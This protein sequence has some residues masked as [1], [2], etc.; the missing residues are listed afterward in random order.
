MIRHHDE[1]LE[2]LV[3]PEQESYLRQSL[4]LI[5]E[6]SQLALLKEEQSL[7][8]ASIDKAL[9]LIDGYYDTSRE[10]AQRVI[11]RLEEL[12]EVTVEP[13]LPDISASQQAMAE[14]IENRHESRQQEG[15]ES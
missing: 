10:E 6:Q 8:E 7:Y 1:A 14:F 3:T 11:E 13:E 2:A 12:K 9:D 4:R 5:L 15:G